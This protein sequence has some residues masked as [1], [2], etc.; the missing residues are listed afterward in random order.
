METHVGD[1]ARGCS[2]ERR[3]ARGDHVRGR[4]NRVDREDH[5]LCAQRDWSHGR[6][7]RRRTCG[8]RRALARRGQQLLEFLVEL[9]LQQVLELVVEQVLEFVVE[10]VFEFFFKPIIELVVEPIAWRRS[11]RARLALMVT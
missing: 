3:R 4:A 5:V 7:T 10:P 9:I 6:R 11:G 1:V 8:A 2:L